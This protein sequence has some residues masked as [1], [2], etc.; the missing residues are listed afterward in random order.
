MA[1]SPAGFRET[2][3]SPASA[4]FDEGLGE[5]IVMYDDVRAA[6][7]P[8]AALLAF[9]QSTYEAGATAAKWDRESLERDIRV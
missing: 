7:S 8:T 5:F 4:R 1:P 9:C 3:V 6:A 2:R